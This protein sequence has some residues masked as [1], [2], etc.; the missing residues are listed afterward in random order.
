MP[1]IKLFAGNSHLEFARTIAGLLGVPLHEPNE[2]DEH[3]PRIKWFGNGNCRVDLK[4]CVTG[5]D[6]YVIQTQAD[7]SKVSD[8]IMELLLLIRGLKENE[9]ARVT[10]VLPY[11]LYARSDK[12]DRPRCVLGAKLF[13]D[14]LLAAGVNRIL[15]MDP[16]FAQID[17]LPAP[18]AKINSLEAKSIFLADIR[19]RGELDGWIVGAPD[20]GESKHAGSVAAHLGLNIAIID[21]RRKDDSEK[22]KSERLIGKVGGKH[23]H[24]FDDEV[25]SGGTLVEA[26][27]FFGTFGSLDGSARITHPVLFSEAGLREI[28]ACPYIRE[29]RVTDT[30]PVPEWKKALCPK[31]RVLSVTDMFAEAIKVLS[32]KHGDFEEFKFRLEREI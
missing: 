21:K 5:Y 12:R 29:L 32:Q 25:A 1:D 26:A 4:T 30:I 14:I 13:V 16:H 9:A 3:G 10:A 31:I 11:F 7:P 23:F 27:N 28:Q 20:I 6:C 22:A 19:Q 18:L 17:N 15:T 24:L 2:C 8:H